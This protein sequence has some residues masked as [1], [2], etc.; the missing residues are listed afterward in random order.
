[1]MFLEE[2]SL[3]G[4]WDKRRTNNSIE[5]YNIDDDISE[6]INLAISMPGKRDELLAELM[7]WQKETNA[8]IPKAPNLQYNPKA[9][10]PP[11]KKRTKEH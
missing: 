2:W 9:K 3:D 1:M 10:Q 6:S 8:P 7:A 5:L 11:K 4:G